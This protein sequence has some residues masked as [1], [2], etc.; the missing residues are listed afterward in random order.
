MPALPLPIF[1]ARS[2]RTAPT[3]RSA[4]RAACRLSLLLVL[5]MGWGRAPSAQVQPSPL[6]RPVAPSADS[7]QVAADIEAEL[8]RRGLTIEEVRQQAQTLGIDLSDPEQAAAR[9]RELGVPEW[10]VEQFLRAGQAPPAPVRPPLASG[11]IEPDTVLIRAPLPDALAPALADSTAEPAVLPYFGYD[12]FRSGAAVELPSIGSIDEAYVVGPGD[13][14]RLTLTGA[15]E[16]QVDLTVD[17]EGR[18]FVPSVGQYT[19]GGQRLGALRER[20]RR[21]LSRSYA[22][23]FGDPPSTFMDLT[24]T[25]L[26]PV[27]VFVTGAVER[28]GA[29]TVPSGTSVFNVLYVVGGVTTDGTLRRIRVV[30]AGQDAAALD[31]YDYL[32]DG[33]TPSPVRLQQGDRLFVPPRGKTV[34]IRGAVRREAR[35]ELLPGEGL[36][37]L[38]GFAS[39]LEAEAYAERFQVERIVPFVERRDPSV[40]R[41]VLDLPLTPVLRGEGDLAL[42]DGDRVR[43][44]SIL[45]EGTPGVEQAL[46]VAEVEGAV[47]QPG[48]FEIGARVRTLRD[49]IAAADGL[50]PGAFGG[51]AAL[52]RL[53]ADGTRLFL[54]VAL[55]DVL[56]D[57]PQANLVLRPGDRLEVF[58]TRDLEGAYTYEVAGQVL[59]P[60][61]RPF[62]DGLSLYDALFEAGGLQDPEFLRTVLSERADL[63]RLTPDGEQR[64]ILRF[65]LGRV[66]AGEGLATTPLRPGDVIRVYPRRVEDLVEEEVVTISGAVKEPDTYALQSN[67]TV[68]D[69]ILQAGG[70]AEGAFVQ[71]VEVTRMA[72]ATGGERARTINVPVRPGISAESSVGGFVTDASAGFQLRHADRVYVRYDPAYQ[73]QETVLVVGEVVFPGEYTLLQDN[74]TLASLIQRAGGLSERAY[75]GGG[76][77]L[78]GGRRLVVD[79]DD[80]VR[81]RR[82]A[83]VVL[84]AGDQIVIPSQPNT[85]AIEGGVANPGLIKYIPGKRVSYY[86]DRAGGTGEDEEAVLIT[87]AS[88]A[89]FKLR[90]GLFPDDPVV[91]DGAIIRVLTKEDDEKDRVDAAQVV[92]DTLTILTGAVTVLVPLIITLT[93]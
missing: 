92:R 26:R 71:A 3:D 5:C 59:R 32:I 65:D 47:Y 25:R 61:E 78:R 54:P 66:L 35:Y 91:E 31:A 36:A 89:T 18:V 50:L 72:D 55:P 34:A 24:L 9:A 69:L 77:L 82:G 70:F 27:Q 81:G 51:R 79:M 7:L 67:T 23:L 38:I 15:A 33:R 48:R 16:F 58:A 74:E 4:L 57:V 29:Y 42:E 86:L 44:L 93:R 45:E 87:Q 83:S 41:Q 84:Q 37:E 53:Q 76:R 64:R 11:V 22:G 73:P 19:A 68:E 46:A 43:I 28:P 63:L 8:E 21:Y 1:S 14:L 80:A 62:L 52:T 13:E 6:P 2:P 75:A 60:G 30:R 10:Q 85:V 90:Q 40:A 49:L 20:L 56:D 88:G 17:T 12:T 39:G